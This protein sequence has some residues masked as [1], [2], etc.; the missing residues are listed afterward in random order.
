MNYES[1]P[2]FEQREQEIDNL[3]ENLGES[4][5]MDPEEIMSDII[6]FAPT[7]DN[8]AANPDYIEQIAEMIGISVEEMTAY[9]IK[10]AQ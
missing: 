9:A 2:N 8:E 5:G 7:E 10:K 1:Q 3:I 4:E 6:T